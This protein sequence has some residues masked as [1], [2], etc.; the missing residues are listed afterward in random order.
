MGMQLFI[1]QIEHDGIKAR[2]RREISGALGLPPDASVAEATN[3]IEGD[4]AGSRLRTAMHIMEEMT[5]GATT[6][7]ELLPLIADSAIRMIPFAEHVRFGPD[8]GE[9]EFEESHDIWVAVAECVLP[10]WAQA[11]RLT[12]VRVTGGSTD[13]ALVVVDGSRRTAVDDQLFVVQVADGLAVKRFRGV[14]D[15]WMVVS[16][17]SAHP[18]RP[19][20]ADDHIVGRVA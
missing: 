18:P 2:L 7:A 14:G 4:A 17:G 12:C 3:A 19:L 6:L 5:E 10:S 8:R 11:A 9:V 13:A 20:R 1:A 16:D 15:Q